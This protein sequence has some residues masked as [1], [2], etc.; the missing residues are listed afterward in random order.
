MANRNALIALIVL[1]VVGLPLVFVFVAFGGYPFGPF[2]AILYLSLGIVVAIFLSDKGRVLRTVCVLLYAVPCILYF[3][4]LHRLQ[5]IYE[6]RSARFALFTPVDRP[7]RAG[8]HALIR[9]SSTGC[10]SVCLQLLTEGGLASVTAAKVFDT[11]RRGGDEAAVGSSWSYRLSRSASCLDGRGEGVDWENINNGRFVEMRF[12]LSGTCVE[13]FIPAADFEADWLFSFGRAVEDRPPSGIGSL[14]SLQ[15]DHLEDGRYRRLAQYE[16]GTVHMP[17]E[18]NSDYR[19]G[20]LNGAAD[21]IGPAIGVPIDGHV[22]IVSLFGPGEDSARMAYLRSL[23]ESNERMLQSAFYREVGALPEINDEVLRLLVSNESHHGSTFHL[24]LA[25]LIG[26]RPEAFKPLIPLVIEMI[27]KQ[28]PT[29]RPLSRALSWYSVE[30]LAPFEARLRELPKPEPIRYGAEWAVSICRIGRAAS[31][32]EWA[33]VREKVESGS[34]WADPYREAVRLLTAVARI[35]SP[36]RAL[37]LIE[38]REKNPMLTRIGRCLM[39]LEQ[40]Y[41]EDEL[42]VFV[43]Q[44]NDAPF[45]KQAEL[46]WMCAPG[47]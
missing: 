10:G 42:P 44:V 16:S 9:D 12:E 39:A 1:L 24:R 17:F 19:Y 22:S 32:E 13:R 26:R 47:L 28:V 3:H 6:E 36:R 35:E 2:V 4:S 43:C 34:Y 45:D 41:G 21:L 14:Q 31:D 20:A 33:P 11:G 25:G 5:T 37:T 8:E 7:I 15:I 38:G 23:A 30:E 46:R 40:R 18:N 29:W 27:E